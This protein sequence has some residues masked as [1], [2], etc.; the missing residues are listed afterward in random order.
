MTTDNYL[1]VVI[2]ADSISDKVHARLETVVH[3]CI[4]NGDTLGVAFPEYN[5]VEPNDFGNVFRVFGNPKGLMTFKNSSEPLQQHG[6]IDFMD[7][8]PIPT[9]NKT[10]VFVRDRAMEGRSASNIRRS[11]NR[12]MQ[13]GKEF[14]EPPAINE[15]VHSLTLQSKSKGVHYT[16]HI[17]KTSIP[18]E[19]GHAFGLGYALPDF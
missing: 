18:T 7:I 8:K 16:L 11:K 5:E 9:T 12:A 13:Q 6:L 17:K 15:P 2:T 1:D 14:V 3:R 19:G 4:F 10:V